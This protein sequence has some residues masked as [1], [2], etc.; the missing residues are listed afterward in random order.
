MSHL[1]KP[2]PRT[3]ESKTRE[4]AR[5]TRQVNGSEIVGHWAGHAERRERPSKPVRS[6]LTEPQGKRGANEKLVGEKRAVGFSSARRDS[7]E[8]LELLVVVH[9][10][11]LCGSFWF[12]GG[13]RPTYTALVAEIQNWHGPVITIDNDLTDE[14]RFHEELAA[15]H[16]CAVAHYV[17][18]A[19][20]DELSQAADAIRR[21]WGRN[22]SRIMVTGLWVGEMGCVTEVYQA[23]AKAAT[24]P[25]SLS[26]Y[27]VRQPECG[28][29]STRQVN[30]V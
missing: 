26:P 16:R 18:D 17:A 3:K 5:V 13:R 29:E 25:V 14:L 11:S 20:R 23:L 12:N 4:S 15:L 6:L 19:F 8:L 28:R 24:G 2:A 21:D 30:E 9:L 27:T 1:E 10:A 22:C 7:K